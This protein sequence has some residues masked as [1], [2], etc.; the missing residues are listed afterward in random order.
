MKKDVM[1][2]QNLKYFEKLIELKTYSKV[3]T[4]YEVSQPSV[5]QGIKRLEED[6]GS[7]IF[8]HLTNP[9]GVKLTFLGEELHKHAKVIVEQMDLIDIAINKL[10]NPKVKI[11][12]PPLIKLFYFS[13]LVSELDSSSI[14][15][16]PVENPSYK[17][18]KQLKDGS[19]PLS[20]V[21]S[22][23]PLHENEIHSEV[24]GKDKFKIIISNNNPLAAKSSINFK[25]LANT[26]FIGMPNHTLQRK[27]FEKLEKDYNIYPPIGYS[28]NNL[29][30]IKQLVANDEGFSLTIG[31]LGFDKS[32]PKT[33]FLEL[34]D[35]DLPDL[36]VSLAY[37]KIHKLNA[38][39]KKIVNV[40]VN[41]P[42]SS[43]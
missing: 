43:L 28:I 8:I 20:L 12:M 7:P 31:N 19:I 39:E 33:S 38:I 41:K 29:S 34:E 30:L 17:L 42:I 18:L 15:I 26:P 2:L 37:L 16:N 10:N 27:V 1:K 4:F 32:N 11:G 35:N 21:E 14:R 23:S 9:A 13:K 25:E 24:I 36:Y 6:I 5:S 3:A 22:I 40:I